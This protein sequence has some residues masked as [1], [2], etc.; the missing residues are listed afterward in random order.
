MSVKEELKNLEWKDGPEI[1]GG[2]SPRCEKCTHFDFEHNGPDG[3]CLHIMQFANLPEKESYEKAGY[4]V[5]SINQRCDC[6]M[7]VK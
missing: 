5:P 1:E 2:N 4:V 7:F 3:Y 6:R